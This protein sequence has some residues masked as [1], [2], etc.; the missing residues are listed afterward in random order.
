[1]NL[2]KYVLYASVLIASLFSISL[3]FADTVELPVLRPL[4]EPELRAET[5]II[6]Y[7][8]DPQ[9]TRAL[10][11]KIMKIQR[12]TQNFVLDPR[13]LTTLDLVPEGPMPDI[14]SLPLALQQH[15]LAIARGLQSTDPRE[16][17]YILLQP[18][19]ID[20]N[21]SNV[22]IAREQISLGILN[23]SFDKPAIQN[24][25]QPIATLP[26]TISR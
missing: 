23:G 24:A 25:S 19:G 5:G 2:L 26:M 1:M 10:Q 18:F 12:D 15:I 14:N 21:A 22:Q 9:Q 4:A 16:G 3:S 8:Q 6:Q 11:H 13:I 7:Q 17:L 20:R